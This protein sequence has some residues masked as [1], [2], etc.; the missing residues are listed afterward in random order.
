[1]QGTIPG[2]LWSFPNLT[3]LYL[4][5]N[6]FV[7]GLDLGN[8]NPT[9]ST[10]VNVSLAYNQLFGLIPSPLQQYGKFQVLDLAYNRFSGTLLPEFSVNAQSQVNLA[11]NRLS[12]NLPTSANFTGMPDIVDR[13]LVGN[14]FVF[15]P[16]DIPS[17][18]ATAAVVY[19]GSYE[20]LLAMIISA[21]LLV[22]VI[23]VTL[24]F[25]IFMPLQ[26]CEPIRSYFDSSKTT[27][28]LILQWWRIASNPLL[29]QYDRPDTAVHITFTFGNAVMFLK[30]MGAG[31]FSFAV[32]C[33]LFKT[34]PQLAAEYR[35]YEYQYAWTF[36]VTYLHDVAPVVVMLC[37][38]FSVCITVLLIA[39]SEIE[40]QSTSAH[41][42]AP[43]M[44]MS[45][46]SVSWFTW[47]SENKYQVGTTALNSLLCCIVNVGVVL[48]VNI[49]Y[50]FALVNSA[51]YLTVIQFAVACFKSFWNIIFIQLS[52][53]A[54]AG[55]AYNSIDNSQFSQ[56]SQDTLM[57]VELLLLVFNFILGPCIAT[58]LSDSSCF[59]ELFEQ[60]PAPLLTYPLNCPINNRVYTGRGEYTCIAP[61]SVQTITGGTFYPPFVYSY[62]C[63]SALIVAYVPV[64]LYSFL[65]SGLLMPLVMIVVCLNASTLSRWLPTR[66]ARILFPP[67]CLSN[68]V[69]VV[70]TSDESEPPGDLDIN[71]GS[72]EVQ[73][74]D[75][76]KMSVDRLRSTVSSVKNVTFRKRQLFNIRSL[77]A[78]LLLDMA[79]L[80]TFGLACPYLGLIILCSMAC[81]VSV[82]WLLI[83][84]YRWI[85]IKAKSW[86]SGSLS[87]RQSIPSL[88]EAS[89]EVNRTL[90][91]LPRAAYKNI[92]SVVI[93]T[94]VF[95][96]LLSFDMIGDVWGYRIAL[97]SM[98][99]IIVGL[100][101][102]TWVAVR[103]VTYMTRR[104]QAKS[105]PSLPPLPTTPMTSSLANALGV[106]RGGN[107]VER[108]G[109]AAKSLRLSGSI[110]NPL[111]E[112]GDGDSERERQWSQELI[113]GM[114]D[115]HSDIELTEG[116][117]SFAGSHN[118]NSRFWVA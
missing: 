15:S 3:T 98:V 55:P 58:S 49:L 90:E 38:V 54:I 7:G 86:Y 99:S 52:V 10:L 40:R 48:A 102:L 87:G 78:R 44:T 36:C 22:V 12:G 60:Q 83:G 31:I 61:A 34:V 63:G 45:G 41:T 65:V 42:A 11:T 115:R 53:R 57:S 110:H 89:D 84:R 8:F 109:D 71:S 13:I 104:M 76:S 24:H 1:M 37:I 74:A 94:E 85:H 77:A 111:L 30:V 59:Y 96:G 27:P 32:F 35:T 82:W 51:S 107:T 62:Q 29:E 72:E 33:T 117:D 91:R 5:G 64:M 88:A 100:P 66:L 2:C 118:L 75:E 18:P 47:F 79:V 67:I 6:G 19:I 108:D 28:G 56:N 70:S 50:L 17:I 80:L 69:S 93:V 26:C 46:E 16:S 23:C 68:L 43:R 39:H 21:L 112:E 105:A 106:M 81:E 4:V 9:G 113:P 73:A 95:W 20:L 114:G 97:Y 103:T 116:K 92:W 25:N 101:I 14:M